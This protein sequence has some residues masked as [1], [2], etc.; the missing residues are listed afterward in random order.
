MIRPKN[1]GLSS[2]MA[3]FSLLGLLVGI[4]LILSGVSILKT[5]RADQLSPSAGSEST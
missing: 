1:T 4:N 2:W 5:F 3:G